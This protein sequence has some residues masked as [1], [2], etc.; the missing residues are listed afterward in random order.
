M[1]G[2]LTTPTSARTAPARSAR[3]VSSIAAFKERIPKYRKN[4][5]S[6]AVRRASHTHRVSHSGLPQSAPVQSAI[7]ANIAPVGAIAEAIMDHIL[8]L[9]A[10]P[11]P[12]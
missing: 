4:K 3:R 10:R 7:K 8:A 2:T 12:A 6:V 9:N 5:M 1:I 11:S